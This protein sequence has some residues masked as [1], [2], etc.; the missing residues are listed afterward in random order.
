M[1]RLIAS[2]LDGT[3]FKEQDSIP[4]DNLKAIDNLHKKQIPFVVCTGK[5]YSV[6]K[7]ICQ[8]LHANFG[9]FGN[10]NQIIDLTTGEEIAKRTLTLDEIRTCFLMIEN[11]NLHVHAYTENSIITT[12]LLYLDLR[13][14]ILSK[15]KMDFVIVPSVLDYI[16]KQN[17]TI[18]K[19]VISSPSS[20]SKLKEELEEKAN[21]SIM[22]VKKTGIYRDTTIDKEYEYLDI[23]PSNVTKGKALEQLKNHLNLQTEEV[24]SIGDNLNDISMFEASGVGVAVHNAYDEVKEV[25][26]FTTSQS[27]ENG[28]FAEA[29]YQFI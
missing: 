2:D 8:N 23:S 20:L 19:L 25:A 13:T 4:Q 21:F 28:A 7:D 6:S 16:E 3:M 27:A 9:I 29:I 18:L 22:Y 5:T 14:S 24:L 11:Q 12:K 1:F 26:N 17:P 15:D 10:G